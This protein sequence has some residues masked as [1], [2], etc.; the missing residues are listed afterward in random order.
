M[1][2][3]PYEVRS[4]FLREFARQLI[5]NYPLGPELYTPS[6][7]QNLPEQLSNRELE[8][9]QISQTSLAEIQNKEYLVSPQESERR[10][11]LNQQGYDLQAPQRI[12]AIKEIDTPPPVMP[13]AMSS[14]IT[15]RRPQQAPPKMNTIDQWLTNQAI[16]SVECTGPDQNLIIKRNGS[17]TQSQTR[18]NQKEIGDIVQELASRSHASFEEGVLK[19]ETKGWSVIGVVSE[20]GG[21]RFLLQKKK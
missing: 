21:N 7:E 6:S 14:S 9:I 15:S 1:D 10:I 19:G 13:Q 17:I 16:E 2:S 3:P 5:I 18:L 8:K 4:L 12:I 11:T 20:F